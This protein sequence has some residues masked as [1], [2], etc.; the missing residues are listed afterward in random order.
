MTIIFSAQIGYMVPRTH[1][2]VQPG[3]MSD[4][5]GYEWY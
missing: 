2:E 1:F 3:A 5:R 4:I